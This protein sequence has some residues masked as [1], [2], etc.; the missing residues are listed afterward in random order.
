MAVA[1]K[2]PDL[3]FT[4]TRA[5]LLKAGHSLFAERSLADVSIDEIAER[6]AISKQTF[7]NHFSDKAALAKEIYLSVRD[8]IEAEIA[9][10]NEGV[11]DPAM[12]VARGVCVYVRTALNDP[13]HIRFV[14][15]MLID[16]IDSQDP[17]NDGLIKDLTN[18]LAEGRFVVR[19]LETGAAF[20][21]GAS[22]PMLLSVASKG[23]RTF[24]VHLTQEFLTLILRGLSV[25]SI[26]AEL[27]AS[28]A[29]NALIR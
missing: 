15:R 21:L 3:R 9:V 2:K 28:Q 20:V 26:E 23:D 16:D 6:A 5:A 17:A 18:G 12:R 11:A 24:A 14:S 8:R 10:A 19:S 13:D 7:Y 22:E 1:S 29:S 4:R 27:I 25:P